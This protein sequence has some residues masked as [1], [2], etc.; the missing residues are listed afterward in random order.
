LIL[1]VFIP[2]TTDTLREKFLNHF[3][4]KANKYYR[5]FIYGA[6]CSAKLEKND[7]VY[8]LKP[9][10]NIEEE[11]ADADEVPGILFGRVNIEAMA[12]GIKT[13]IFDPYTLES[14]EL[15]PPK[16]FQKIFDIKNMTDRILQLV[17]PLDLTIVIP[18]HNRHDHLKN[19]LEDLDKIGDFKIHII[20]G[21]SFGDN[22][23]LGAKL[24]D[25]DWICLLNDDTR[26]TDRQIFKDMI[27][28]GGDIVGCDME[29]STNGCY[30]DERGEWQPCYHGG[31]RKPD[32]PSGACLMIRRAVFEELGGFDNIFITGDEDLDL[33]LRA[34]EKGYKIK[35]VK[36]LITHYELQSDGRLANCEKNIR[37]FNKKWKPKYWQ[38][39]N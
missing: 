16:D 11:I 9:K 10:F 18:H 3:I 7:F 35:I 29:P 15:T 13:T 31:E 36:N 14:E 26:I 6:K 17:Q 22:C 8:V 4:N 28:S 2:A 25:T 23:N 5:V 33:F 38:R 27:F 20:K 19:I 34:E 30:F 37:A 1:A 12:C 24:A 21:G 39:I 32:Y